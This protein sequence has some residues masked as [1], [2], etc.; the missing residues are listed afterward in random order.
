MSVTRISVI[1][2][3]Y[4]ASRFIGEAVQSVLA[5][6]APVDQIIVVDDGS[7]DDSVARV[8]I[9]PTVSV[10]QGP[11]AG[12]APTLNRGIE[13]ARGEFITFLDADDRW[14]PTKIERQIDAFHQNSAL[15]ILFT[16]GTVFRD[17]AAAAPDA[18]TPV[19]NGVC[20]SSMM[21]TRAALARVGSFSGATGAHDFMDWYARAKELPAQIDM[22]E[23]VLFERRIHDANDGIVNQAAQRQNY[24]DTIKTILERRRAQGRDSR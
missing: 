12:I 9:D 24:F 23:T 4:N 2:P 18:K 15:E 19:V 10:L 21:L 3:M 14:L 7:T 22:V 5:Q 11:H 16:Q 1:I 17:N 6:T 13:A 20:K 8:P